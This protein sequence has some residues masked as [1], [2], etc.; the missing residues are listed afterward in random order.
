MKIALSTQGSP[1]IRDLAGAPIFALGAPLLVTARLTNDAPAARTL[2][3]PRSSQK[4]LL[5]LRSPGRGEASLA[6]LNPSVVDRTGEVT[7]P[8]SRPLHLDP[9]QAVELSV[10]LAR[11]YPDRWLVPGWYELTVEYEHTV[12]APLRFA[13]ELTPDAVPRLLQIA[14]DP[15]AAPDPRAQALAILRGLP[16]GPELEL[17]PRAED[18]AAARLREQRNH[19]HAQAF[20][21]AWPQLAATPELQ[22]FFERQRQTGPGSLA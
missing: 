5:R 7:A 19:D 8:P 2:D 4:T 18:P 22:R 1:P 11:H 3:D 6:E 21:R 12:S 17:A 14:L 13:I 9:G 20:L 15:A 16:R 10:E